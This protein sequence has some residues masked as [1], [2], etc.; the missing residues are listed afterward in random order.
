MS[1]SP[2]DAARIRRSVL[3]YIVLAG[4]AALLLCVAAYF[5]LAPKPPAVYAL[6]QI[7]LGRVDRGVAEAVEQAIRNV[8]SSPKPAEAW[9]RLGMLLT[10]HEMAPDAADFCYRSAEHRNAQ[11]VRWPYYR[12]VAL[13]TG[14]PEQAIPQ[15]RRA[16]RIGG[17]VYPVVRL[18]L[19]ELLLQQGYLLE[20]EE[21]LGRILRRD[22]ANARAHLILAR[23]AWQ[24]GD[25]QGSLGNL[26]PAES[27]PR[28]RKAALALRAQIY[29]S[30]GKK[31]ASMEAA[32]ASRAAA[33]LPWENPLRQQLFELRRGKRQHLTKADELLAQNRPAEAIASLRATVAKYPD[34]SWAWLL[35]GRAL[36]MRNDLIEA[37]EALRTAARLLPDSAETQFYLGVVLYLQKDRPAAAVCFRTAAELEP[38]LAD[39]HFNLAN[40]L[41]EQ[42]DR[43][44][45]IE[46][47]RVGLRCKPDS[48][49]AH[50]L[51]GELLRAQG[52]E[53]QGIDHL[54][55]A[56]ELDPTNS[57]VKRQLDSLRE[58]QP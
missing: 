8:R 55:S 19:A 56:L 48:A 25:L 5:A 13:A 43:L 39:A 30:Q 21:E 7:D 26:E 49:Q 52:E 36:I 40:C 3:F 35:L 38:T 28:T 32:S 22:P 33:D 1:P 16:A 54:R 29:M 23:V 47:L 44:A 37:A 20:A 46:A 50:A 57:T 10:A 2:F 53:A 41:A 34:L 45:A 58:P 9:G 4:A 31:N 11:D 14:S 12:G 17:D 6:P 18:D 15:L 27:D 51:L 24:R 42:G